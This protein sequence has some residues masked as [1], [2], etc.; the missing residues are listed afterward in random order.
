MPS[1]ILFADGTV[2][3]RDELPSVVVRELQEAGKMLGGTRVRPIDSIPGEQDK[4]AGVF[5]EGDLAVIRVYGV[6]KSARVLKLGPKNAKL[7]ITLQ[8]GREKVITRPKS[9]L[10]H[11]EH[12]WWN[13][14]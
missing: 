10:Q 14:R 8:D 6:M 1:Q 3:Y 12:R 13:P 11:S 2:E 9:D 7:R 4:A 5:K